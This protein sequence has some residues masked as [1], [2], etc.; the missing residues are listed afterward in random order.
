MLGPYVYGDA[1]SGV[2]ACLDLAPTRG[3]G[4]YEII[5]Q[6]VG[7]MFVE[8]ALVAKGPEVELQ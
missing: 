8:D 1:S 2:E 7:E 3:E 4:G 6:E 5:E